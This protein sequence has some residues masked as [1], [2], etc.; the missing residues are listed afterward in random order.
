M[1]TTQQQTNTHNKGSKYKE[2]L[3]EPMAETQRKIAISLLTAKSVKEA[4]EDAGTSTGNIHMS[5]D[6]SPIVRLSAHAAIQKHEKL[7]H[8]L[9]VLQG[10]IDKDPETPL[11]YSDKIAAIKL[12]AELSGMTSDKQGDT[13]NVGIFDL[14]NATEDQ[15]VKELARLNEAKRN[16]IDVTP[17]EKPTV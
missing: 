13:Y 5:T 9:S 15:L 10:I 8:M 7:D 12:Q 11:K 17:I 16:V 4:A 14:R 1:D 2:L 3:D 6:E